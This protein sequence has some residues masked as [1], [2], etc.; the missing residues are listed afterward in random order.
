MRIFNGWEHRE[1]G[2][3][4]RQGEW[5]RVKKERRVKKQ[6]RKMPWW[7]WSSNGSESW[8]ERSWWWEE[9]RTKY[10]VLMQWGRQVCVSSY[11]LVSTEIL[12]FYSQSEVIF[13]KWGHFGWSPQLHLTVW[14]WRQGFKVMVRIMCV[15]I[16]HTRHMLSKWSCKRPVF[17]WG[18]G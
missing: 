11:L 7:T 14:G 5:E 3:R 12:K 17:T 8:V 9:S 2:Q 15:S 18:W 16:W 10:W 13:V 1:K 4:G 6:R